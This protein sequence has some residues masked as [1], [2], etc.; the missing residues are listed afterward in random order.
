MI[1]FTITVFL[2]DIICQ[3]TRHNIKI[4]FEGIITFFRFESLKSKS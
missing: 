1:S 2:V 3:K 4:M